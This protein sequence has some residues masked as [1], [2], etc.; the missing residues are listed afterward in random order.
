MTIPPNN[1]AQRQLVHNL[2]D[3]D[4]IK[5]RLKRYPAIKRAFPI[6]I[7][8]ERRE[9]PP[10]FCHYMS[11]R[12]GTYN[13]ESTLERLEE[14]LRCA[15]DLPNW[16][17]E[18]NMLTTGEFADFWSLVWQLQFAEYLCTVG[19]D[20]RW[21]KSGPD[22]SVQF[23][24]KRLYVECYL[25]RKSFGLLKFIDEL[26]TKLDPAVR[27][28][29]DLCLRFS[30]P[31]DT[32]RNKFLDKILKR[33]LDSSYLAKA[34]EDA[35]ERYPVILYQ[36]QED[37][38]KNSLCIYVEGEN[39]NAYV[40]GI[41]PNRVGEPKSYIE[42]VLK[43][44][45]SNKSGSNALEEHHPNLLAVNFLL[46]EDY[47]LACSLLKRT[48]S[49]CLPEIGPTIDALAV[50]VVGIDERLTKEKLMTV[51]PPRNALDEEK[52]V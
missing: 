44:A 32:S 13:D 33:F 7:L 25:P 28:Q 18:R 17:F 47:Q 14:L 24:N 12:L 39:A 31:Q 42:F 3:W 41:V 5:S 15:E 8:E 43:E 27:V 16:K 38:H 2:I 52:Q 23:G 19:S 4:Q 30:L 48:Q 35:K 6:A 22:L 46:S 51:K 40:P 11:W 50:S 21:D 20:V 9:S 36:G 34:K 26:L 29:Y 45:V 37:T 1:P 10:Y 49:L